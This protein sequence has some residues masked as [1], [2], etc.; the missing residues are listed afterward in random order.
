MPKPYTDYSLESKS[1]EARFKKSYK[2]PAERAPAK[3]W[4]KKRGVRR[5]EPLR[6]KVVGN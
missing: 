5:G 2:P 6:E 4:G 3:G 1:R